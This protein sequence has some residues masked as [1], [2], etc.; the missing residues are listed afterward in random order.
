MNF[1][2]LS[3][4][5]FV[6]TTM[7]MRAKRREVKFCIQK[8]RDG[9]WKKDGHLEEAV[10]HCQLRCLPLYCIAL[11]YLVLHWTCSR[12]LCIVLFLPPICIAFNAVLQCT[13][14]YATVFHSTVWYRLVIPLLHW[15]I[16]QSNEKR[17]YP[18]ETPSC[19]LIGNGTWQKTCL[20]FT[21][22]LFLFEQIIFII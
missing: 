13:Q 2:I 5:C 21:Q 19:S 4:K 14:F 17:L 3:E 8:V 22:I 18:D 16:Y 7:R 1:V 9:T 11:N 20:A 12:A 6:L 15:W 10:L